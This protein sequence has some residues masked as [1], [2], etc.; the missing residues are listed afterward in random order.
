MPCTWKTMWKCENYLDMYTCINTVTSR[1]ISGLDAVCLISDFTNRSPT[2]HLW[3]EIIQRQRSQWSP[4]CRRR[5][6]SML[7]LLHQSGVDRNWRKSEFWISIEF[8]STWYKFLQFADTLRKS[9]D[10]NCTARSKMRYVNLESFF[11]GE[12]ETRYL[13]LSKSRAI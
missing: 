12:K 4:G 13:Q 6:C 11:Q 10:Y 2:R 7:W 9:F 1:I 3:V 5:E 8:P